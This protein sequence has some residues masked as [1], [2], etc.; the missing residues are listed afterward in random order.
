M[1]KPIKLLTLGVALAA[2]FSAEA[3]KFYAAVSYP[4][5]SAGIYEFTTDGY[6]PTLIA[7]NVYASGGGIAYEGY[8]YGIRFEVISGVP[9]VA[10]QS[11]KIGDWTL[12]DNYSGTLD[13][14]ATALAYNEDRDEII[15]CFYNASGDGF[16]MCSYKP[17]YF[18]ATEIASL[19]KGWGGACYGSDGKLYVI[20]EDGL[21]S[22][23][24]PRTAEMSPIGDTGLA[25]EWITGGIYEPGT[26]QMLYAVKTETEAALYRVN[27]ATAAATKLYNLENEEQLGG[28]FYAPREYPGNVPAV[29]SAGPYLSFSGTSM[30]GK[31]QF[32][33][34]RTLNDGT[35][36]SGPA[37]WHVYANGKEVATGE[38]TFGA[39]GYLAP[40]VTLTEADNYNFAVAIS[41][42]NGEGPRK[43][44]SSKKFVGPDTPKAPSTLMVRSYTP[45]EGVKL[46]WGSV[47]SGMN[48][49]NID[50][51]DLH[52]VVTRYPDNVVV[53]AE[54]QTATSL[55]DPLAV[56]DVRTEYHY[57]VQ[58]VTGDL[59]S[60]VTKSASFALGTIEPPFAGTFTGASSLFG[61]SQINTDSKSWSV[62]NPE[63]YV[64]TSA[65][66]ADNWLILPPV[67]VREGFSYEVVVEARSYSSSYT[68]TFEVK[69]GAAATVEA[70]TQDVITDGSVAGSTHVPVSGTLSAAADG[71][72][73]LGIHTTTPTGGGY[74]YVKSITIK[75]GVSTKAP[76]AVTD[77]T[78]AS[79][80]TG[81]HTAT[82]TFTL[83]AVDMS[84]E[85]LVS[86][87]AVEL[88][89]DDE[90]VKTVT[91]G[92]E[93]GAAC[94][95]T[96]ESAPAGR[97][98][99]AVSA[100]NSYGS[101][102]RVQAETF[103]GFSAPERPET[104]VM[105]E[106]RPGRVTA[107]WSA[108]TKDSEGHTL[109]EGDVKYDVYKY[110]SDEPELV[111]AG[112]EG[113]TFEFDAMNPEDGQVFVQTLVKAV[114]EGGESN[115]RVSERTA[116]GN[117]YPA[118]WAE[119]FSDLSVSSLMG[120]E[121]LAGSD[122]WKMV[123]SHANSQGTVE[124]VDGDGG[125]MVMEGYNGARC[126]ISTGKIDLGELPMPAFFL[127][128]NNFNFGEPNNNLIEVQVNDGS[129][130]KTLY[131][132]A[133]DAVGPA[134][135]WS[136]VTVPLDDYAGQC[137]QIR[138]VGESKNVAYH[139][140][141]A[142]SVT[143]A[144]DFNLMVQGVDAPSSAER[145]KDFDIT[146]KVRNL[147]QQ[148]A[149]G[150]KVNLYRGD[151]LLE[152]KGGNVLEPD[153]SSDFTFTDRFDVFAPAS[154]GYRAEVEYGVD[155]VPADNVLEFSVVP[156]DNDLPA[157][158]D[159]GA[160]VAPEAVRL[161]WSA[162]AAS[163]GAVVAETH[164]F[165]DPTLAWGNTLPGWTF[166]D[167]DQATIGGIGTR[168]L[169]VSGKQSFF[170]MDN[171]YD[172]I[173]GISL[174]NAHSGHQFLCS[175][176][177]M[178]GQ[179]M[180]QSDDWAIS[181]ELTGAAQTVS[182]WASSFLATGEDAQYLETFQ[183]LVSDSGTD[184]EDF[185]LVEEFKNIPPMWKEYTAYLPEGSKYFAIRAVSY[186][187]Y[188]LFVDDVTFKA[189]GGKTETL[190][191]D[192]YNLYRDGQRLNTAPLTA[193][194][195]TDTDLDPEAAYTYNVTG[196][197]GARESRPSNDVLVDMK[198]AGISGG[199]AEQVAI[200]GLHGAV[201]ILGAEGHE[202]TL[203]DVS[204]RTVAAGT[205]A[206]RQTVPVC[207]GVYVVRAAGITAKVIVR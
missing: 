93:V 189:K 86:I 198:S 184:V 138:V 60:P 125:F 135:Q 57:T 206:A 162:P 20:D 44:A 55:T 197:T 193:C 95:L 29:I 48:G 96:D 130:Y 51:S 75:E 30:T 200:R 28:F 34:P 188:M 167:G 52:Y 62:S 10:Q 140:L 159:L 121:I 170:V 134:N 71:I 45:D 78:V 99:Y 123:S 128:V 173:N 12:S 56:P 104:I 160:A 202:Y 37:T 196:L 191:V 177:V 190:T 155:E 106:V 50:R 154:V 148:R 35:A 119:S 47:S 129:G 182:L 68:E 152:S 176:Y 83:P 141:D 183:V 11:F 114:T 107:T 185:T 46:S 67:R 82:A 109:G 201:E 69:A 108:V 169:P 64:G 2:A 21:L 157:V 98:T 58:A 194:E 22:T 41:N 204:G 84:G 205:A 158:T 144:A 145:N 39:S 17:D 172:W 203:S 116:C 146:V 100:R 66:P 168:K 76:G 147:G 72:V 19:E 115:Y 23:V 179:E 43:R 150:F 137:V 161:S 81:K 85:A 80:A 207:A 127:Y 186:D 131:S 33:M 59:K 73:Y 124:A 49:G 32:Q 54:G 42:E 171:T 8:Y 105:S 110:I 13:N 63:V 118:P 87:D 25:T 16:R 91:E 151:E 101:G 38:S 14:V 18:A 70:L 117:P 122:H 74:L 7:R 175:M 187:K 92:L 178:R 79:D 156:Q 9:G 27:L 97:H 139:Y 53:S 61:W 112:V 142:F 181:P 26:G 165:D 120:Y 88:Y 1:S 103:V 94:S 143:S 6:A 132:S 3:T 166:V 24:N 149:Q 31:V 174:Y 113:T 40:E 90:L 199:Y 136:K 102:A 195:Y 65:N 15:G 5:Q 111:K 192:G 163:Q 180:I 133:V 77:L 164:N 153:A 36:A 4:P 126:G 89:R